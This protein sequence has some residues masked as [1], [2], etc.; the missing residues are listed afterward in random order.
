MTE[1]Q[2]APTHR[3]VVLGASNVSVGLPQ[4]VATAQSLGHG[5]ADIL[6][7][8]GHG[9]SYGQ[10]S[11]V[12][13]RALPGI[14]QCGLW[15]ALAEREPLP[16]TALL[17]DI[18]NDLFYRV[19]PEI[20]AGWVAECVDRLADAGAD[21]AVTGLPLPEVTGLGPVRYRIFRTI[22]FP[23]WGQTLT[24]LS[25]V[26]SQVNEAVKQH[27][28]NQG[29]R[30]TPLRSEWYGFDPIHIKPWRFKE[31]WPL[32]LNASK[33]AGSNGSRSLSLTT[34]LSLRRAKPLEARVLGRRR[35]CDQPCRVLG[36]GTRVSLF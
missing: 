5:P 34:S 25:A 27:A 26:A 35:C 33:H 8:M 19:E 7:A 9:R 16:T 17:T 14:L 11:S 2:P 30:H 24:H 22:F 28:S 23:A 32:L 4:L 3:V 15:E 29:A 36:D 21:V 18:G 6:L 31:V 10:W 1:A 13:G 12:P 20:L